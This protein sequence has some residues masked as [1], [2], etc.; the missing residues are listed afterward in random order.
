MD[1]ELARHIEEYQI[2]SLIVNLEFERHEK[3]KMRRELDAQS[4]PNER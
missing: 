4:H 2:N 1:D 3:E